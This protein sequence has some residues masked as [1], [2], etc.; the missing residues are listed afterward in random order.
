MH[1]RQVD[2]LEQIS[3]LSADEAKK[4]LVTSLKDEAKQM[5]WLLFKRRLKKPN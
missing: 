2:M 4:E 5:Q 3:G 1:K